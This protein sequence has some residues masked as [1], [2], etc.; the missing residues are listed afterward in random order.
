MFDFAGFLT[1]G[2]VGAALGSSEAEVRGVVA[3]AGLTVMRQEIDA[4]QG[5]FGIFGGGVEFLFGDSKLMCVQ[6]E[7]DRT[8]PLE[9]AG[10]R[11]DA[12]TGLEEFTE[13]LDQSGINWSVDRSSAGELVVTTAGSVRCYFTAEE[14]YRFA[15]AIAAIA[16]PTMD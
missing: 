3:A 10:S 16:S 7:T 14:P 8:G 2:D 15:T 13:I 9:L 11:V 12:D 6:F 1:T 4:G 5:R